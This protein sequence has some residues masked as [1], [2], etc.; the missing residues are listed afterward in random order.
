MPFLI[1]NKFQKNFET[2]F[3]IQS[4]PTGNPLTSAQQLSTSLAA[5]ITSALANLLLSISIIGSHQVGPSPIP[6]IGQEPTF[7]GVYNTTPF[8]KTLETSYL[9]LF[10]NPIGTAQTYAKQE[11]T[12]FSTAFFVLL[13]TGVYTPTVHIG[14]VT[15]ILPD[16]SLLSSQLETKLINVYSLIDASPGYT[17]KA[18]QISTVFQ[19]SLLSWINTITFT[20]T[21]TAVPPLVWIAGSG[22]GKFI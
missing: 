17:I 12:S 16:K 19:E 1:Q 9:G 13:Q 10:S 7:S 21:V 3:N 5:S 18:T 2:L 6:Y 15:I 20:Q 22:T 11:A 4:K 8:Q 14:P